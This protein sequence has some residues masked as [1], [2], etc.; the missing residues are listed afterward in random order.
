MHVQE[1]TASHNT[2][3]HNPNFQSSQ[4][5]ISHSFIY[6]F[7]RVSLSL[8]LC[9]GRQSF[10][11]N[12]I[13]QSVKWV[14]TDSGFKIR[15]QKRVKYF[16]FSHCIQNRHGSHVFR[17]Y[18]GLFPRESRGRS[19]RLTSHLHPG[20]WHPGLSAVLPSMWAY[21]SRHLSTYFKLHRP[22][23]SNDMA[24]VHYDF[25]WLWRATTFY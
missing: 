16:P 15:R 2:E 14:T 13:P 3:E 22:T 24:T 23:V 9:H 12:V 6:L 11:L 19:V 20:L 8:F 7:L 4:N 25:E 18:G 17:G 21:T 5:L 10:L 1:H